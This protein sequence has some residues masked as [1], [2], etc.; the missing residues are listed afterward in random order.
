LF[1]LLLGG[2][3]PYP[4]NLLESGDAFERLLNE[5]RFEILDDI[6]LRLETIG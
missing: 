4:N 1:S 3:A 5:E 2:A 6:D